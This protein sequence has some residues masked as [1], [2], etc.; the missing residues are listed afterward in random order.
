MNITIPSS[1]DCKTCNFW[2]SSSQGMFWFWLLFC[3]SSC[4]W[5]WN[6]PVFT[7]NAGL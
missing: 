1:K 7:L 3:F 4:H 5:C 2:H 6:W